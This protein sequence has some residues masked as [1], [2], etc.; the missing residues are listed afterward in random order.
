MIDNNRGTLR[1]IL[2]KPKSDKEKLRKDSRRSNLAGETDE[3]VLDFG[4]EILRD[5]Q[6][7]E[8]ETVTIIT[9][10]NIREGT[11][12]NLPAVSWSAPNL[13]IGSLKLRLDKKGWVKQ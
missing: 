7:N 1:L 6:A 8:A 10:M 4:D 5:Q 13:K 12:K 11:P 2:D 3:L 9:V